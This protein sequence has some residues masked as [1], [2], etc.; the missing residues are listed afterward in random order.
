MRSSWLV[1]QR[2][3]FL[4]SLLMSVLLHRLYSKNQGKHVQASCPSDR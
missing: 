1:G 3:A 2:K 4:L